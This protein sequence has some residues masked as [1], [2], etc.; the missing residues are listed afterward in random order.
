MDTSSETNDKKHQDLMDW[1]KSYIELLIDELHP[2]GDTLEIGFGLGDSAARIQTYKLKSHTIIEIDPQITEKA[3][4]W[5]N[6]HENVKVIQG[7]WQNVLSQ[8]GVFDVI[9]FNDYPLESE[10]EILR[11]LSP[12]EATEI[13]SNVE[14]LL[15]ELEEQMSQMTAQFSDKELDDFNQQVGQFNLKNWTKFLSNLKDRGNI[16]K[17]QYENAIKKYHLQDEL[18]NSSNND[19]KQADPMLLFLEECLKNHMRKGS[20]FSSFLPVSKSKYEDPLFF[21]RIIT[22]PELDYTENLIPIKISNG[23]SKEVLLFVVK[24]VS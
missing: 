2:F 7:P 14:T 13:S 11:Q 6:K 8:L 16:S 15:G 21:D 19:T 9:F 22:N 10:M 23:K 18:K 17:I 5:G 12:E 4:L 1:K 20:R 24:K 3:K